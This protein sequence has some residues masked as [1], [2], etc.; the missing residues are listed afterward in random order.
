MSKTNYI[1]VGGECYCVKCRQEIVK[2]WKDG[3]CTKHGCEL[4]HASD[5][6]EPLPYYTINTASANKHIVKVRG[7]R[8]KQKE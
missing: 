8:R 1:R 7:P 5:P 4:Y 2:R 3:K 6:N